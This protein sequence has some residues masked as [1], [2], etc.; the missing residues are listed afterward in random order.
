MTQFVAEFTTNHMGNFN[1]LREMVFAAKHAG[2]NF[3]KMQKKHIESYYSE[4][5]LNRYYI[6]PYGKTYKD[7][8][9][10]FEF[11]REDFD[12]FD[13][14]CKATKIKWFATVQDIPS[15]EFMLEYKL[16]KY[17][18]ASSSARN[19]EFLRELTKQVSKRS[20]LVVSVGG[21]NLFQIQELLD[22]LGDRRIVLQHCV[23]EYPASM[24]RLRLGNIQVLKD[25]FETSKVKIGYSGHE[26]GIIPSV[27]VGKKY[28][29]TLL[30]RHFCLSRH[31]FVHHIECSL[32]PHE[33]KQMIAEIK[34]KN[35][36]YNLPEEV[37]NSQ[38]GMSEVEKEF[39]EKQTYGNTYL[40]SKSEW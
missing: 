26:Q 20:Q 11:D 25:N 3:I 12:R 24:T 34:D 10:I 7:Y 23:A 19:K 13:F 36:E 14:I 28:K 40:G 35:V 1:L 29:P 8:R 18:V 37:F 27:V 4:D 31:S 22:T 39:L 16:P 9:K 21:S 2:A 17:K 30:E 38:F 33:F 15:L 32:E 5:K 6:S